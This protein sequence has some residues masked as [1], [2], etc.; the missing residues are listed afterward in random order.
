MK[1]LLGLSCIFLF[2]CQNI[3]VLEQNNAPIANPLK[4]DPLTVLEVKKESTGWISS[5][6]VNQTIPVNNFES[7]KPLMLVIHQ[8]D[9]NEDLPT[10]RHFKKDSSKASSHYLISRSG[11]IIQFVDENKRAFHAGVSQWGSIQDVNSVSI[12]IELSNNGKTAYSEEQIN[13]LIK[14]SKDIIERYKIKPNMVVGHLEVAPGRKI[15][16]YTN[17]PWEILS[18][19]GITLGCNKNIEEIELPKGF[20]WEGTLNEIGY[21]TIRPEKALQSFRIRY[22]HNENKGNPTIEEKKIMQ[23]IVEEVYKN[24]YA[25]KK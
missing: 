21:P 20:S 25:S 7:R 23:C 11:K 17:F 24:Q 15:D 19:E 12:G 1:Y 4:T 8:T 5:A 6:L 18:K 10:I 3:A 22:F 13:S 14:L 16:P 2:G 9:E